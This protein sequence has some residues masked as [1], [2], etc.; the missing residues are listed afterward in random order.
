MHKGRLLWGRQRNFDKTAAPKQNN[1]IFLTQIRPNSPPLLLEQQLGMVV[2]EFF[3]RTGW[4][5]RG[6]AGMRGRQWNF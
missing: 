4:E 2:L 6:G 3:R 5:G 1:N